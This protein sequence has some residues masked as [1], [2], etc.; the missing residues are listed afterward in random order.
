MK[1]I[2]MRKKLTISEHFF[3]SQMSSLCGQSFTLKS[4]SVSILGFYA[5]GRAGEAGKW[6][7]SCGKS[8]LS[9]SRL[10]ERKGLCC[11]KE[12]RS[13]LWKKGEIYIF[14]PNYTDRRRPSQKKRKNIVNQ[15]KFGQD[16]M[17]KNTKK[18]ESFIFWTKRPRLG[19]LGLFVKTN[20]KQVISGWDSQPSGW[21]GGF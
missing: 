11:V 21:W 1:I 13:L 4:F 12:A 8:Y 15:S 16:E 7:Q 9:V 14:F 20:E 5:P 2:Y 17:G 18:K 6:S 3:Q 10:R 19:V